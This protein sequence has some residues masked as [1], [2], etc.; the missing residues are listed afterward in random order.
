MQ[1]HRELESKDHQIAQL[2][3]QPGGNGN[4][5]KCQALESQI[6]EL[7]A[8]LDAAQKEA[9]KVT[10]MSEKISQLESQLQR[11]DADLEDARAEALKVPALQVK[12]AELESQ[13]K[14]AVDEVN[15]RKA[16]IARLASVISRSM[17]RQR[18][19]EHQ[20]K[21]EL[22]KSQGLVATLQS[23][24]DA[25]AE[26]KADDEE[27]LR[28]ELEDSKAKLAEAF[29]EVEK[30]QREKECFE[31]IGENFKRLYYEAQG[32]RQS[33]S[34]HAPPPKKPRTEL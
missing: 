14:M 27:S 4:E 20:H 7:R 34:A 21:R 25:A 29:A 15:A 12:I 6:D 11:T 30:L 23:Q 19:V 31:A 18:M 32:K 2:R 13:L 22:A 28:A 33:E 5:P 26:K 16:L 8:K 3:R 9:L 24:L 10:D 1:L 17:I